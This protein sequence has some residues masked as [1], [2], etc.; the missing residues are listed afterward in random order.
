MTV[1]EQPNYYAVIPANVRY[2]KISANA[3]L[4]YG[5]ITALCNST[6]KCWAGNMY[7]AALYEVT[8]QSVSRW[9]T[10]LVAA[11]FIISSVDKKTGNHRIIRIVVNPINK[12]VPTYEEKSSDINNT[13]KKEVAKA[14]SDV[15][16]LR[17][18]NEKTGRS[19][20]VLPRGSA[21]L[22]QVF[23]LAEIE[24]ALAALA[25]DPWHGVRIG[26]LSSSYLLRSTTIDMFLNAKPRRNTG[27]KGV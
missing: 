9:I 18:L 3:K 1:L 14:T 16:L 13:I 25:A 22:L 15:D 12:N 10:E 4:L 20:R 19:F 26:E 5:E 7:F 8:V 24:K 27:M 11:G 21:K 6:G 23:S 2:A 17:I